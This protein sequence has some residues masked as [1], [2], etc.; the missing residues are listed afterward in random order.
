MG[1]GKAYRNPYWDNTLIDFVSKD[2]LHRFVFDS[3]KLPR[4][5]YRLILEA[6]K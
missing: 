1:T 4:G 6:I 3:G 5:K 2:Q